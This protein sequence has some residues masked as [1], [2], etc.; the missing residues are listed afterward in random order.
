MSEKDFTVAMTV[1]GAGFLVERELPLP[2]RAVIPSRI[3]LS[4]FARALSIVKTKS[5]P[6]ALAGESMVDE[7]ENP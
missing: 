5:L 7:E 6:D 1:S 3:E 4:N 2:G